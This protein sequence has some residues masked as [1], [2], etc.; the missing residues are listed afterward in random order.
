MEAI[1]TS[2]RGAR[3]MANEDPDAGRRIRLDANLADLFQPRPPSLQPRQ[4][5]E[6]PH[7]SPACCEIV[8]NSANPLLAGSPICDEL[9]TPRHLV[10]WVDLTHCTYC[11]RFG[12]ACPAQAMV[13]DTEARLHRHLVKR[14]GGCEPCA[15][16]CGRQ[17]A[18]RMEPVPG[19]RQPPRSLLSALARLE[20]NCLRNDWSV[21]KKYRWP[22]KT[23][24]GWRENHVRNG[25]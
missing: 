17:G 18:I 24:V 10:P 2:Y 16:S 13:V 6:Y 12:A 14:C 1:H 9:V 4:I 15:M 11:S 22:K 3:S 23:R 7:L 20:P 8:Q 5:D 19:Y 25:S 21:W